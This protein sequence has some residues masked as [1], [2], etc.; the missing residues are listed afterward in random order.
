MTSHHPSGG[1]GSWHTAYLEGFDGGS[2]VAGSCA[3]VRQCATADEGQVLVGTPGAPAHTW[4]KTPIDAGASLSGIAC[5]STGLC[6]AAVSTTG[7]IISSTNPT[8]GARWPVAYTDPATA[9]AGAVVNSLSCPSAALCVG[10]DSRGNVLTS[11]GPAGGGWSSVPI[12]SWRRAEQCVL[13]RGRILPGGRP[14]LRARVR[15]ERA[16]LLEPA[17]GPPLRRPSSP[18]VSCA[19]PQLCVGGGSGCSS[20]RAPRPVHPAAGVRVLT[21]SAE[22]SVTWASSSSRST[23]W[24]VRRL[25]CVSAGDS[26]GTIFASTSPT[27]AGSWSGRYFDQPADPASGPDIALNAVSCSSTESGAAVDSHGGAVTSTNP[28]SGSGSLAPMRDLA[29]D[30]S[31]PSTQLCIAVDS[32]GNAIVG[33]S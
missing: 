5:P 17:P 27:T 31:C 11:T 23:R 28:A 14:L 22:I 16:P 3:S 7:Q 18:G 2:L 26:G 9:A 30:I 4:S 8:G 20:T 15:L 29:G 32:V 13:H 33:R 12:D 21:D 10:V 19:S 24:P 6:F 25:G 1:A